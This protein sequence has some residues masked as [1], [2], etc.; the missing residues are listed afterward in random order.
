[1]NI[2]F[3]VEELA[4]K[5]RDL[6]DDLINSDEVVN[7][8][9]FKQRFP[10]GNCLNAAQ[11]LAKYFRD[12]DVNNVTVISGEKIKG[13]GSHAWVDVDGLI[14]DITADQFEEFSYPKVFVGEES[15][16]HKLY[17]T[18]LAFQQNPGG[19]LVGTYFKVIGRKR[20]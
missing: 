10:T 3:K 14:V 17:K 20:V 1:M 6:I 2:K 16:L 7:I 4:I 12:N 11:M 8:Y 19:A 13:N 9:N 15:E 18:T 5:F